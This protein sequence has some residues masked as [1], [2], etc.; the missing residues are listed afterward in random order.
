MNRKRINEHKFSK[1][2]STKK[3]RI[4]VPISVKKRCLEHRRSGK[5][6]EETIRLMRVELND[7]NFTISTSSWSDWKKAEEKLLNARPHRAKNASHAPTDDPIVRSFEKE[8]A[9]KI[10]KWNAG[11]T[12]QK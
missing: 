9:K 5:G 7:P 4:R 6:L 10:E 1:S 3:T 2:Q 11:I 12:T 8:V